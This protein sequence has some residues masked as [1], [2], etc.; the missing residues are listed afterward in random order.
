ML[1]FS[2]M[3][4]STTLR[5]GCC[6]FGTLSWISQVTTEQRLQVSQRPS[7]IST[8]PPLEYERFFG[9]ESEAETT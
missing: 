1:D 5:R 6:L 9:R 4:L 8:L 3:L 7:I 2:H